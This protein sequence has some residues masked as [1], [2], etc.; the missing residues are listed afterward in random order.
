MKTIG[1][2]NHDYKYFIPKFDNTHWE[3]DG[4]YVFSQTFENCFLFFLQKLEI[5]FYIFPS[6][7]GNFR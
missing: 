1:T 4:Y 2:W 5:V 7:V 6:T 3:A